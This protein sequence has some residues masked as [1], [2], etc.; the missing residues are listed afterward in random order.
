VVFLRPGFVGSSRLDGET[1][2]PSSLYG[3]HG[4]RA[5][6]NAMCGVLLARGAGI[7]KAAQDEL[8]AT[9]VAP[10]VARWLGFELR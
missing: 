8:A 4:Y 1:I 2:V 5:S 10:L 6:H 3:Q 7:P 9:E